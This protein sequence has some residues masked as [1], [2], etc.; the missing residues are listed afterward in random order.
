MFGTRPDAFCGGIVP[1]NNKTR[2]HADD[3]GSDDQKYSEFHCNL[4]RLW[5][6]MGGPIVQESWVLPMDKHS[7]RVVLSILIIEPADA[8][9]KDSGRNAL[10]VQIPSTGVGAGVD[11]R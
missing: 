11:P 10:W 8:A 3:A 5:L 7:G 6:G 9:D 1:R 2:D 4:W